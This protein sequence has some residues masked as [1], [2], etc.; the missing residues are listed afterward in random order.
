MCLVWLSCLKLSWLVLCWL[1][2][3][4]VRCSFKNSLKV[5]FKLLLV[6][7]FKIC[8]L[9]K[10]LIWLKVLLVLIVCFKFKVCMLC[11]IGKILFCFILIFCLLFFMLLNRVSGMEKLSVG[12]VNFVKMSF[13]LVIK[14]CKCVFI[15]VSSVWFFVIVCVLVKMVIFI[16]CLGWV[17]F[18]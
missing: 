17:V 12:W 7:C 9:I 5:L 15:G 18:I 14:C 4:W 2:S 1:L 16:I 10:V 6:F 3:C 8:F 13:W 11:M